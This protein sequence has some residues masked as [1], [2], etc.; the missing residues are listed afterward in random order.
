MK[1]PSKLATKAELKAYEKKNAKQH[2]DIVEKDKK[3]DKKMMKNC[4]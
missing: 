2:K 1:K 3:R 4:K